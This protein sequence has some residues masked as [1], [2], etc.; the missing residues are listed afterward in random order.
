[1]TATCP[2]AC[3]FIHRGDQREAMHA[4]HFMEAFRHAQDAVINHEPPS[5]RDPVAAAMSCDVCRTLHCAALL[6]PPRWTPRKAETQAD[7][8]ESTEEGG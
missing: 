5:D 1:M 6:S 3:H 8:W 2:C 7:G 4:G